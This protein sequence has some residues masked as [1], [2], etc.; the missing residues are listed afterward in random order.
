[1]GVRGDR[2]AILCAIVSEHGLFLM[3]TEG[4]Q[5]KRLDVPGLAKGKFLWPEFLPDGENIL[6]GWL[7][8]DEKMWGLICPV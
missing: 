4:S 5:S 1:M 8:D 2:G 6:F 7:A 3:N